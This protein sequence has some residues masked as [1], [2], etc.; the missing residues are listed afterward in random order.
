MDW[1]KYPN[2]AA[3]EFDCKHT[4]RNEMQ[5]RFMERLQTFRTM[6]GRPMTVTSGYRHETHPIETKKAKPGE[7]AKGL[8]ADISVTVVDRHSFVALAFQCGFPRIGVADTFIHLGMA[9]E[10]DG[11]PS[12]RIWT[13]R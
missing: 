13:Y 9:T 6:W 10:E 2:F 4:G 8:C 5:A 11:H 7:H 12:P 1:S 3:H